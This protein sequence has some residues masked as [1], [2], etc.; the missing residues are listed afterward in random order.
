MR[1]EK[2][3]IYMNKK[4]TQIIKCLKCKNKFETEID[5]QGVPYKK[6]CKICKKNATSYARGLKG[7]LR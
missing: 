6:I 4:D 2:K 7:L 3:L 5:L 1:V